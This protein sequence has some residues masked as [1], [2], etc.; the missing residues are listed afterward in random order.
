M[1]DRGTEPKGT[2]H[3]DVSFRVLVNDRTEDSVPVGATEV[4]RGT[5]RGDSI[6][7]GTDILDL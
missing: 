3:A 1:T 2:Y 5:E 7:L 4:S 6:L